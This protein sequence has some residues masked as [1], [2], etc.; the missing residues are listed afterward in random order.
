MSTAMK[1][2]S[3]IPRILRLILAVCFLETKS[4]ARSLMFITSNLVQP[5]VFA[6][7]AFYL[8]RSSHQGIT[9]LYAGLGAGLMGIWSS[10]LFGSGGAISR[11]RNQGTLEILV[12]APARLLWSLLGITLATSVLGVYSLVATLVWGTLLFRMPI[13]LGHPVWFV[14]SI[15]VTVLSLGAL[16]LVMAAAFVLYRNANTLS[17]M[18]EYPISMLSGLLVPISLLPGWTHALSWVL[19][20]TWGVRAVRLAALGGDPGPAIAACIGL[21]IVYVFVG[22]GILSWVERRVRLSEG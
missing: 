12:A 20:P 22:W 9:L 10:T 16:G 5:I 14:F 11:Q 19:A 7:I 8:F 1:R 3:A 4:L 6:T 15:P 18:L 2:A 21:G 17:N 13:H